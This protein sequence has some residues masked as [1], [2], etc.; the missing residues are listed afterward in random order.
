MN[1]V[2]LIKQQL[3]SKVIEQLSS[4]LGSSESTTGPAVAAAVPSLLSALSSLASSGSGA[5]KLLSAL[6]QFSSGSLDS[7]GLKMANQPT[8]VLEQGTSI[9]GSLFG[10][11]TITAIV[12][13]LARFSKMSP[14]MAQKLL[15]Y[16]TPI[17]LGAIASKFTGKS[18]NAQGLTSLFAEEKSHIANALPSGFS[19]SDV[20]G[21]AAAGSTA[22]RSAAHEVAAAGSSL[23]RWLLPLLGLAALGLLFWWFASSSAP[24]EPEP[25]VAA[26]APAQIPEAR[27]P[28]VPEP[29]KI[30]VPDVSQFSTELKDTFSKLTEALTSVKDVASAEAALPKLQDLDSKL[31]IAKATMQKLADSAKTTISTLV[32]STQGKLRELVDKVLAIPGV[33]EKVRVVADSIMAKLTDLAG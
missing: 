27:R 20:P 14:G 15:A 21:L 10:S 2:D 25:P 30:V 17:I 16:L 1:L 22:A 29:A 23:P 3:S 24:P 11:T 7:L 33:G 8:S 6:G 5:Q 31:D 18:M 13:A 19:L 32:K 4:A 28:V 26:V 12:N 9:L